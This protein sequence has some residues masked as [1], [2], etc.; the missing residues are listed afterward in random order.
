MEAA[1]KE[2]AAVRDGRMIS[3][4]EGRLRCKVGLLLLTLTL[5]TLI[6]HAPARMAYGPVSLA[7]A[8]AVSVWRTGQQSL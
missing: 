3:R 8:T 1:A 2:A 7:T 5:L 4:T 6:G